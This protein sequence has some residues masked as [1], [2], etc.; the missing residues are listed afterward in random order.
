MLRSAARLATSSTPAAPLY[1]R[2]PPPHRRRGILRRVVTIVSA[3]DFRKLLPLLDSSVAD[4][5]WVLSIYD[6]D[7]GG[8]VL[9]LPPI[10]SNDP[11]L[12]WGCPVTEEGFS[13]S[14]VGRTE[15][16]FEDQELGDLQGLIFMFSGVSLNN[17][18]SRGFTIQHSNVERFRVL[19]AAKNTMAPFI[20]SQNRLPATSR[21]PRYAVN[22][23]VPISGPSPKNPSPGKTRGIINRNASA[24]TLMSGL[25]SY[26]S[27]LPGQCTPV[28]LFVFLDE[29][30]ETHASSNI[31]EAAKGLGPVV[32]L[33]RPAN[34]L[35][36][37]LRKKLQ[38][39]LE[40]QIRFL[41]K[42]CRTLSGSENG[43]RS[44][45]L[46]TGLAPLFSLDSSR[47]VL[48]DDSRS[49]QSGESLEFAIG[50]VQDVLDGKATPDSL[51]LENDR[52][53]NDDIASE[54]FHSQVV[55]S[56]KRERGFSC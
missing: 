2:P 49:C 50:L 54:G 56:S 55:R 9:S 51:L 21:A 25:G 17:T 3:T 22:S 38:S 37:G 40:A 20:K 26:T 19:Q 6:S 47:A 29:F 41:I 39:S 44:S 45:G 53:Q 43:L 31:E 52:Q 16:V 13:D 4:M 35:E 30:T 15:P 28:V 5:K 36:S 8:I 33:A 42:K 46:L 1:D 18:C 32:V 10:A 27:F 11:I 34:K 12:S 24:T 23:Q 14:R 48:L 7:A